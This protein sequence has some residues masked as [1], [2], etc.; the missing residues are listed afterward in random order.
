MC[1][2]NEE[3]W[4]EIT[5]SRESKP[6]NVKLEQ[7][8]ILSEVGRCDSNDQPCNVRYD[9]SPNYYYYSAAFFSQTAMTHFLPQNSR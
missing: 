2:E 5:E 3:N 1:E 7:S 8:G 9:K 6:S 4:N